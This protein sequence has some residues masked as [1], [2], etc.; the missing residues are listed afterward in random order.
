MKFQKICVIGLGYIGLPTA[1]TFAAHG[2][3]VLGVDIYQHIIDTLN[4]G[5][6]HIHEPGLIDEF[7]KAKHA[8]V[9]TGGSVTFRI[10]RSANRTHR[11]AA[12]PGD[13]KFSDSLLKPSPAL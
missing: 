7:K 10:L 6:I 11:L 5:E 12:A 8:I 1:S 13:K 3:N 2:V 9:M 4:K